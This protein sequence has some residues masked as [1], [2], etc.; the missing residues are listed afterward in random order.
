MK[1]RFNSVRLTTCT[2]FENTATFREKNII[3]MKSSKASQIS[4]GNRKLLGEFRL[5]FLSSKGQ[6]NETDVNCFI[7]G[8]KG[9]D[10]SNTKLQ[11]LLE[12]SATSGGTKGSNPLFL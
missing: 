6:N 11:H 9:D 1:I 5:S 3:L 10:S 12:A 4:E 8:G 2:G 7:R